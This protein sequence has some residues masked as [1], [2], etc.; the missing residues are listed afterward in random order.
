MIAGSPSERG[1]CRSVLLLLAGI[2]GAAHGD[3]GMSWASRNSVGEQIA[4]RLG[5]SLFLAFFAA[6]VS[7]PLAILLGMLAVQYRDRWPDKLVS[8]VLG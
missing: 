1:F 2:A 8:F 4:N 7:V 6:L 5:N 3:F